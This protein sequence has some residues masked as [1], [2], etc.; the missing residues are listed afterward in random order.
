MVQVRFSI[1]IPAYN[2][3]CYLP[4]AIDSALTQSGDDFEIILVDDGSLDNTPGIGADY[5]RR[6]P[7]R[8]RYFRQEN[9]GPARARNQGVRLSVGECLIFLD[10]DD[11]LLPDALKHFRTQCDRYQDWGMIFGGHQSRQ[12]DGKVKIHS[13]P[14]LSDD[15]LDNFSNYLRRSFGISNGATVVARNVFDVIRYPEQLRNS[16]DLPVFAQTLALFN[17]YSFP[18]TVLEVFKHDNSLRNNTELIMKSGEDL[19]NILFDEKVLPERFMK[20]RREY[21]GRHALSLFRSL[22]LAGKCSEA[23]RY[24]HQA[25]RNSPKLMGQWSY[26]SKYFRSYFKT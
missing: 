12:L 16:E 15:R 17:C 7:D 2:Y 5:Q 26:L 20:M 6:Y 3:G 22:Y 11:R 1:V 18:E 4:R 13:V 23:R 19:V 24:F 9:S 14:P 21:A 10:A 25:I 8:F